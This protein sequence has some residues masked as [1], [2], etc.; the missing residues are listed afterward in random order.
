MADFK[1]AIGRGAFVTVMDAKIYKPDATTVE[2]WEDSTP[3][4]ILETFEDEDIVATIDHLKFANLTMSGPDI[5]ITGGRYANTLVKFGK[6]LRLE[7][8]SAL[9]S[10]EALEELGGVSYNETDGSL[11]ITDS[12]SGPI[13]IVG[14]T[15]IVDQASGEQVPVK[16]IIY[17]LLPDSIIS[18]TQDEATA[19]TFDMNGDVMSIRIQVEPAGS[20]TCVKQVS[21]FYSIVDGCSDT[22]AP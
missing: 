13:T 7:M 1:S 4:E 9:C 18:L 15:I 21:A 10:Y 6:S 12:F 3:K 2:S 19:A 16:I 14:D 5:I 22:V 17:R 20:D 11:T 8:K